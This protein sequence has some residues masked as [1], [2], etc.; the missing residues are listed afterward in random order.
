MNFRKMFHNSFSDLSPVKS[1][2]ELLKSVL[3]RTENMEKR[4]KFGI[5]KGVIA[6]CAAVAAVS[7]GTIG[8]AA[9][10]LIDFNEIFGDRIRADNAELGEK[11][12]GNAEN[13]RWTVSDG[14]YVVNLKGVTGTN[15]RVMAVVEIARADGTPTEDYFKHKDIL[16]ET[17][18]LCGTTYM[19]LTDTD[20]YL[21]KSIFGY[22]NEVGNIEVNYQIYISEFDTKTVASLNGERI[23]IEGIGF[24]P[25]STFNEPVSMPNY[26]I[27]GDIIDE[28]S[29][30][31]KK[32]LDELSVLFLEWSM[33]F[34]YV[35]SETSVK[36]YT[37]TDLS[38]PSYFECDVKRS[39]DKNGD[40]DMESELVAE[41]E[42][43]EIKFNEITASSIG[44][45]FS[46]NVGLKDY[47]S[48]DLYIKPLHVQG[49]LD[50]EF[51][52]N[53]GTKSDVM[54]VVTSGRSETDFETGV[55]ECAYSFEYHH[56]GGQTA[57]DL[58]DIS[59]ISINGTVYNL[60]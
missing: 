46:A 33:E 8:A 36:T 17:N 37:A 43:F 12:I 5:K 11:L 7:L 45:T 27:F 58:S 25:A 4:K 13:V 14:D 50:I 55:M 18:L 40:G 22:I 52:R 21:G 47:S 57:L 24:Y 23:S 48:D 51:I 26:N 32:R 20:E 44:G 34:D 60:E 6:V 10:G 54:V 38:Q 59:A 53:D 3:E 39:V 1:N 15:E 19:G 29:E 28:V 2:N 56:G 30:E 31:G 41:K 35:P 16:S 42:R 9:V 49:V